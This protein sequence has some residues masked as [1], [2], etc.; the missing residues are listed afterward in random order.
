MCRGP[1]CRRPAA[2]GGNEII[3]PVAQPHAGPVCSPAPAGLATG[4]YHGHIRRAFRKVHG[5]QPRACDDYPVAVRGWGWGL[6]ARTSPA[7]H[8][9][10]LLW[11]GLAP[12]PSRRLI[13][14][15]SPSTFSVSADFLRPVRAMPGA[16]AA[17]GAT[18]VPFLPVRHK[19][20]SGHGED[21]VP[22]ADPPLPARRRR[23]SSA[24]AATPSSSRS[25]CRTSPS[26]RHR[27]SQ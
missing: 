21:R 25:R 15:R 2:R 12:R 7:A 27:A 11:R 5:L 6:C 3:T 13:S 10:C 1:A 18:C 26:C 9:A 24:G 16:G 19:S 22:E 8:D 17:R 20:L 23:A 4:C 14:P